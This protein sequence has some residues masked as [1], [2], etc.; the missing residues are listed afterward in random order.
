MEEALRLRRGQQ[1]LTA[2]QAAALERFCDERI[3]EFL[4]ITPVDEPAVEEHLAEAY[5]SAGL[6]PPTEV[7]WLDGPLELVAAWTPPGVLE[8]IKAQLN[9]R[10][11]AQLAPI[12]QAVAWKSS[13][14]SVSLDVRAAVRGD[15]GSVIDEARLTTLQA[16]IKAR[17][18]SRLRAA[19]SSHIQPLLYV[20]VA[21]VAYSSFSHDIE[22]L[23]ERYDYF[24]AGHYDGVDLVCS[25][26]DSAAR[27]SVQ[28]TEDVRYGAV[29]AYLA[30]YY[31]PNRAEALDWVSR[32]VSGYWLGKELALLVRRPRVLGHDGV[33]QLHHAADKCIEYHDSWGFYA[34]HG[35]GVSRK[36]I[37]APQNLTARDFFRARNLE[38]RRVI[39]A[40]LGERFASVLGEN[41]IDRGPRGVLYEV[42]VPGER[43]RRA[44][45]VKVRDASTAR[46]YY[47]RVPPTIST[48]EAA[49]AWTFG[50]T[51][52]EYQPEQES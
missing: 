21:D 29:Y 41:V 49:V 42:D 3:A 33:G 12:A 17:L 52:A 8:K 23:Y 34:W 14:A 10:M 44:R 5:L 46:E 1:N 43:D 13:A 32:H 48:A 9:Q 22:E 4:S 2:A 28:S 35:V 24:D 31:L 47:L 7:Y 37:L 19:I 38:V 11:L 15:E 26:I 18:E 16:R 51:T 20:S 25:S 36:V 39:Q 40:R 50:L 30:R 45:Y 6:P 27:D